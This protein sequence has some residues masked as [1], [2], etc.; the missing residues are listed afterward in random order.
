MKLSESLE[1]LNDLGITDWIA[2]DMEEA[3]RL[4]VNAI[5]EHFL[6]D[7]D[8]FNF[9]PYI[10]SEFVYDY[11]IENSWEIDWYSLLSGDFADDVELD[12]TS[13][14]LSINDSDPFMGVKETE[15]YVELWVQEWRHNGRKKLSE[16]IARRA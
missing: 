2:R 12:I 15:R 5:A 7:S 16:E 14:A 1:L 13:I 3:T 4:A 11:F 8:P 6:G 9:R 10:E